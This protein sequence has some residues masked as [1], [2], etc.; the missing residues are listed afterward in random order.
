M[1]ELPEV[2]V[3]RSG[4]AAHLIAQRIEQVI[5]RTRQLRWPVPAQLDFLMS[6][7]PL[8]AVG[9]R[10]KYLYLACN[11]GYLLVHLGMSGTL[12]IWPRREASHALTDRH[13][14][15][16]WIFQDHVLRFR[17][18]R[19]FGAV[20]WHPWEAGDI[21][22]HPRLAQLGVEPLSPAFDGA[23]LYRHTRGRRISIKQVLL[24]GQIVVGVGNIYASESLFRA[25]IHPNTSAGRIS[26]A[27]Y[28]KLADAI[29]ITL[30]EAIQKG[31]STLRDFANSAGEKGYFQLDCGVYGRAGQP[32]R[33]CGAAIRKMVQQQRATYYCPGCQRG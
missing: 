13:D 33:Q 9:R 16:D 18:P 25:G 28:A 26:A 2:E 7:H 21:L 30:T 5:V 23:C 3:I 27:Q 32:C 4:I 20:L 19:R 29:R 11:S 24:A 12:R 22:R 6:G 10:G 15:I 1:P 14:H 17:D 8:Q 31:G